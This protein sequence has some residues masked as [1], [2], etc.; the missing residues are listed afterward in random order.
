MTKAEC[1]VHLNKL[2]LIYISNKGAYSDLIPF[3]PENLEVLKEC[4]NDMPGLRIYKDKFRIFATANVEQQSEKQ[5][6]T[7]F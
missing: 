3:K 6:E 5:N 7:P 4:Q 2:P 1:L